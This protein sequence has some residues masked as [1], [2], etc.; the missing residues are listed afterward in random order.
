MVETYHVNKRP[1]VA[2]I[3]LLTKNGEFYLRPLLDAL[4]GQKGIDRAEVIV[5][6]SGSTDGTLD[7]VADYPDVRLYEISPEE[8]GHGRTRNL[9]ARLAGGRFL[10]YI[11]QDATPEGPDWLETLLRPF[12][13]A[14]VAGVFGRQKPRP[15]ASAMERFFLLDR[16]PAQPETRTLA[17]GEQ[18]SLARCFFSTVSGATRASLWSSHPFRE[19]IIMSEDQAWAQE[20]MQAGHAI[21]YEPRACVLHSHQY[22]IADVF[23]RNFDSGYSIRQIFGGNTGIPF[24]RVMNKLLGEAFFVLREGKAIDWFR[25]LP[26]EAA[27]HIGFVLGT[28]AENM[29]VRMRRSCSSLRYFWGRPGKKALLCTF[30]KDET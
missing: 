6:D 14:F 5:I 21:A 9:G 3:I 20:V 24:W 12:E 23:R 17:R 16:Y 27:R 26:Y 15:E 30:D 7:I 19:D 2:S 8:F 1:L 29:P 18:A 22:G 4:F 28:H 10:V 25:F 11:P 13:N